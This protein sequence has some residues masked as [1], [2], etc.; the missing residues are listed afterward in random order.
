MATAAVQ[1]LMP[2]PT[3]ITFSMAG[4][5]MTADPAGS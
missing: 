4:A 5:F 1:A 2:P 3:M